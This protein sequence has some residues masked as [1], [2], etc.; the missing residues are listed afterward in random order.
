MSE[1]PPDHAALLRQLEEDLLAPKVAKGTVVPEAP[2]NTTDTPIA[3]AEKPQTTQAEIDAYIATLDSQVTDK[4]LLT[5]FTGHN[6]E[7]AKELSEPFALPKSKADPMAEAAPSKP[8]A[9]SV[10]LSPE[11]GV[12]VLPRIGMNK[13]IRCRA[14][15]GSVYEILKK[16]G[17]YRITKDGE[18]GIASISRMDILKRAG[19]EGWHLI[20]AEAATGSAKT[21]DALAKPMPEEGEPALDKGPEAG[22]N[23]TETG[24]AFPGAGEV[25]LYHRAKGEVAV[26]KQGDLYYVTDDTGFFNLSEGSLAELAKKEGWKFI[27]I[28]REAGQSASATPEMVQLPKAEAAADSSGLDMKI[29]K[30][31]E[32]VASERAAFIAVEESQ[33]S[34]WKNLSWVFRG[35]SHTNADDAE[36]MKY[37]EFYDAKVV[38]L[39]NAELEKLKASGLSVKELRPAMATLIREFEFDEAERIYA[40]RQEMRL[41]KAN[42]PLLEKMKGLWTDASE[43]I[44]GPTAG[45]EVKA[46]LK[47]FAGGTAV[48][49]ES[50]L[51]GIEKGGAAYNKLMRSKAG[52]W[53][54]G[55]TV[56]GSGVVVLGV[57]TGGV[58]A[59]A[60]GALALK[61]LAA[62]AG[63]AVTAE[64]AMDRY[65]GYRR[66]KKREGIETKHEAMF[67]AM[68]A[69]ELA[70]K[71]EEKTEVDFSKL[72]DY[73]KDISAK[74]RHGEGGRRRNDLFRKSAAVLAGVAL[75]SGAASYAAR[76]AGDY[77]GTPAHAAPIIA[78]PESGMGPS[79]SPEE[80]TI[81][82]G[83]AAGEISDDRIL[84]NSPDVPKISESIKDLPATPAPLETASISTGVK[85]FLSAHE[86]K[87]GQS[88]WKLATKAVQ[89]MP[90]MDDRASE[91][92]A[93]LVELKLQTKLEASPELARA[94][95][96][97][98]DAD[99]K[100]SPHHIQKGATIEIGRLLSADEMTK[101]VEEAKSVAP[102]EASP[103]SRGA[104]LGNA[105]NALAL[106]RK[107]PGVASAAEKAATMKL[108]E[109]G[110][111]GRAIPEVASSKEKEAIKAMFDFTPE[112]ELLDPKGQVM[113]YVGSLPAEDQERLFR[114]FK[115]ISAEL[116][117]T[118]E[119][120][121]G[122]SSDMRYHPAQH[123]EFMK[124]KVASVLSDHKALAKN[125]LFSYDRTANPLHW[126]QMEEAAKFAK[127]SAKAFGAELARAR[128][129]ESVQEYT[130]RM[131]AL[132]A[133]SGK[134]IP[135]FRMLD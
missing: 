23:S 19:E 67:D 57:G 73:L 43:G 46:W 100:F 45:G 109:D 124:L 132:A 21:P 119:V 126:S 116:F 93:K 111:T 94:A 112:Q 84:K 7:R 92:F 28:K 77:V 122:E 134:K 76:F 107:V 32:E 83:P 123:P 35:L 40:T 51:E 129:G 108:F 64:Q 80:A 47:L 52:K 87:R 115:K 16:P 61:R 56:L 37:Q 120:M 133:Q 12:F 66:N 22:S 41:S 34:A 69:D 90:G 135:G 104:V 74:V 9:A 1:T 78:K 125:P 18:P 24:L 97:T 127:A 39:Q 33:K 79:V 85:E 113:K 20:E 60:V 131:A 89:G 25:A 99:G 65:A 70:V 102:I 48:M 17:G 59:V 3:S 106:E 31:R 68:E 38:A 36:M 30:L 96:F 82:R 11:A 71:L 49:T 42:Q 121:S 13:K 118:P 72:E 62:G 27:E 128:A 10:P 86:V 14:A 88:V 105:D 110:P 5:P 15:D 63:V 98:P 58:G 2:E 81:T 50:A 6:A 130:L 95:G 26:T 117:Q 44:N 91:R 101:L 75:G 4:N 114:N 54:L 29:A 55:A 53:V 103:T 8:A